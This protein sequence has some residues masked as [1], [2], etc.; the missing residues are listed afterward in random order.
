M[1]CITRSKELLEKST[2]AFL[3]LEQKSKAPKILHALR[4]Y[5]L[6]KVDLRNWV[7]I[8]EIIV[9]FQHWLTRKLLS[10]SNFSVVN[11]AAAVVYYILSIS[12]FKAKETKLH[13][14]VSR[15]LWEGRKMCSLRWMMDRK[16]NNNQNSVVKIQV[17]Q[18]YAKKVLGID[19]HKY[20]GV[21]NN[22][23]HL[24]IISFGEGISNASGPAIFQ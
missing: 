7:I 14:C 22:H 23:G 4:A 2:Y 21:R 24:W 15:E 13:K 18:N 9:V 20:L 17:A 19:V 16:N 10:G 6:I 3:G 1:G 8:T 5:I 11:Y 12:R